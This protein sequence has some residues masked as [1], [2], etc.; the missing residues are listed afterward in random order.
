V[1]AQA[2]DTDAAARTRPFVAHQ[3]RLAELFPDEQRASVDLLVDL[4]VGP[5]AA[6]GRVGGDRARRDAVAVYHLAF[7]A[8]RAHLVARTRPSTTEIDHLV[9][10]ATAGTGVR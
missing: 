7:G 4:L 8:L 10:F 2:A 6:G 5:L 9:R 3:D 1:L